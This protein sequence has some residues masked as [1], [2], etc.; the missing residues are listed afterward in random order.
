MDARY[1]AGQA[2]VG[3]LAN[4]QHNQYVDSH[5]EVSKTGADRLATLACDIAEAMA[6]E[7]EKRY[8]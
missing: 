2:L 3:L 7:A 5:N 8:S 4:G 1:Y 6:R